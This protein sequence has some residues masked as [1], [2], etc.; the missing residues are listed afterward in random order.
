MLYKMW[1]LEE[2]G[3]KVYVTPSYYLWNS[4][5][6]KNTL[7]WKKLKEASVYYISH[8]CCSLKAWFLS[9]CL[10]LSLPLPLPFLPLHPALSS[11]LSLSRLEISIWVSKF[12]KKKLTEQINWGLVEES[13]YEDGVLTVANMSVRWTEEFLEEGVLGSGQFNW[14]S[15]HKLK[16]R[17]EPFPH[18][19]LTHSSHLASEKPL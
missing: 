18:T 7:K 8:L 14:C 12:V 13:Y 6:S 16:H 19:P 4:Y 17:K 1:I 5:K 9:S 2:T 15:L 3:W 10:S 11:S